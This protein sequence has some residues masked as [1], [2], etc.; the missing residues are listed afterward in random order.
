MKKIIGLL[1]LAVLASGMLAFSGC[2][3]DLDVER[4]IPT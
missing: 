2:E 1:W 3:E 4:K